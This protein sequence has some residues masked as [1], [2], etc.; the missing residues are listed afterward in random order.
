M[1]LTYAQHQRSFSIRLMAQMKQPPLHNLALFTLPR[2]STIHYVD[3]TTDETGIDESNFL[4][5]NIKN[6]IGIVLDFYFNLCSLEMTCRELAHVFLFLAANGVHP[7]TG[8]EVING[9][10]TKRIN[11]IMQLCGFYDEAGEFSF[12]VGLPG[13]SGVGGMSNAQVGGIGAIAG[14]LLGGGGGAVKGALGGSAMA[15]LGTLAL[16]A[17]KNWQ[18]GS[19]P[20][21]QAAVTADGASV[22]RITEEEARQ[23]ATPE[24]AQL[25]LRSMISAAK[26]DGQI[27]ED[28]MQRI[29]GKLEEGGISQE[30]RQFVVQEMSKPL[31]LQGLIADVPNRQIGAQVYASA[32][33]AIS[34]DTRAEQQYLQQLASGL[35][36][37]SGTV[38]RLHQMVGA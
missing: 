10:K 27:Q 28:E 8:I 25:C 7:K 12:K 3:Y 13:K 18:Q 38:Q 5:G 32:L 20:G 21:A 23:M 29:V 26:A 24:T 36:L 15:V 6:D 14:A 9:S 31:D 37:D 34:V 11:A 33:L 19:Q 16:S 30:E 22:P 4:L 17:L 2:N 35:G 1:L